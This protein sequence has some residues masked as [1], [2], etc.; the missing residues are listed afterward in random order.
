MVWILLFSKV[1]FGVLPFTCFSWIFWK[2]LCSSWQ[3][4]QVEGYTK[5]HTCYTSFKSLYIFF[6]IFSLGLKKCSLTEGFQLS[7]CYSCMW[8]NIISSHALFLTL[9]HSINLWKGQTLFLCGGA[10]ML[11]STAFLQLCEVKL[12]CSAE[13]NPNCPLFYFLLT[14]IKFFFFLASNN[15]SLVSEYELLI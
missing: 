4:A 7:Y 13:D 5:R 8:L 9:I 1:F 6:N 2:P 3:S 12:C 10:R 11:V 15:D 14:I